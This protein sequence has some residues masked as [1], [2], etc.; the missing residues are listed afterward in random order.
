MPVL[1]TGLMPM[2]TTSGVSPKRIFLKSF[3]KFAF[4]KFERL[5]RRFLAGL[6]INAGV[7]V[8]G[9]FAEDDHVHLFRVLHGRGH[10]G[11]ILHGAQADVEIEHLAQR[12][13]ERADAAADGRG[14]RAF[15]ADEIFLERLDGVVRQPVVE[16]LEAVF[17][18]ENLEPGD[19]LFAAVGFGH[20]R[21]EHAHAG[22]PDVRAGAV[23]ADERDD[24]M[25][26]HGEL[27]VLDGNFSAGGRSHVFISHDGFLIYV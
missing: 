24:R 14:E 9:V 11:E 16:F 6:E 17:A 15:D 13:V 3:G 12:D 21:V 8:L 25:I 10:A 19:F 18:G 7:N 5:Q 4:E 26:G 23:A 22:G 2:P 27:A 20:R 1:D